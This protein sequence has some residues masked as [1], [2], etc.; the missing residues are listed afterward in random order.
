[1]K[2]KKILVYIFF[3]IAFSCMLFFLFYSNSLRI[4][5]SLGAAVTPIAN[6]DVVI[7]SASKLMITDKYSDYDGE[8]VLTV[9][10]LVKNNYLSG[11]EINPV[12][13][14]L[15]SGNIRIIAEVKNGV[16]ND[17]YVKNEPFKNVFNCKDICYI[18]DNNYIV[19]NNDIYRIIKVDSDGLV[20]ITNLDT[21]YIKESSI[22]YKLRNIYNESNKKLVKNVITLNLKD[23]EKSILINKNNN[24]FINTGSGYKELDFVTNKI[25]KKEYSNLVSVIVLQDTVTYELGD[26]TKANPYVITE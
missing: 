19:F 9:N 20:Y 24:L 1:M 2:N 23:I 13:N 16:I 10:D 4:N 7:I 6:D 14:E 3:V 11:E 17:I 18:N 5:S 25:I 22:D 21:I 26:G 15:Y 8:L 12:S